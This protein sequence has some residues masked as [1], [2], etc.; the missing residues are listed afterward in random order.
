MHILSH[1]G[2]GKMYTKTSACQHFFTLI[3]IQIHQQSA[4][5]IG[6]A[7]MAQLAT[8]YYQI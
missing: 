3:T 6:S 2:R 5:I 8:R 1:L 7:K 4:I